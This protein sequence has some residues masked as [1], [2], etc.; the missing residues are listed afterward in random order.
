MILTETGSTWSQDQ[1]EITL[2]KSLNCLSHPNTTFIS[3]PIEP[4]GNVSVCKLCQNQSNSMIQE[5][6]TRDL[7][8]SDV[9]LDCSTVSEF[10]NKIC[11]V[12]FEWIMHECLNWQWVLVVL[13]HRYFTKKKKNECK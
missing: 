5:I 2:I 7:Y 13:I 9:S 8:F 12:L 3:L 4:Y 11:S 6:N 10:F 1:A